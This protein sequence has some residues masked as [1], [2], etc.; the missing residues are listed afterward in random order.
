MRHHYHGTLWCVTAAAS[1]K[2]SAH[3]HASSATVNDRTYYGW[4]AGMF[5]HSFSLCIRVC[6]N[7]ASITTD[8]QDHCCGHFIRRDWVGDCR[9]SH[10]WS[11]LDDNSVLD[12]CWCG[13]FIVADGRD[14]ETRW[15]TAQFVD[16]RVCTVNG[17]VD[18]NCTVR[19]LA[20]ACHTIVA[21][22]S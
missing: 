9:W 21:C 15:N 19:C 1:W 3:R 6:R 7:G 5:I 8:S 12:D 10:S 22:V 4:F 14:H 16:H 11:D 13:Q 20:A 18:F 17:A 2:L